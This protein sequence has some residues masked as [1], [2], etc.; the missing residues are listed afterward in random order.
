MAK[1]NGR[2]QLFNIALQET[3]EQEGMNR[4]LK[5]ILAF[6][7]SLSLSTLIV[8]LC[9]FP[10]AGIYDHNDTYETRKELDQMLQQ[11]KEDAKKTEKSV[12]SEQTVTSFDDDF[13]IV[14]DDDDLKEI[15]H[16]DTTTSTNRFRKKSPKWLTESE[17]ENLQTIGKPC[18]SSRV[19]TKPFQKNASKLQK[20]K[21]SSIDSK[22]LVQTSPVSYGSKMVAASIQKRDGSTE[23]PNSSR[24]LSSRRGD[25]I[26]SSDEIDDVYEFPLKI[27]P[28]KRS[29]RNG[30]SRKGETTMEKKSDDTED[31]DFIDDPPP[32]QK[33]YVNRT[34]TEQANPSQKAKLATMKTLCKKYSEMLNRI[35]NVEAHPMPEDLNY[36]SKGPSQLLIENEEKLKVIHSLGYKP[37]KWRKPIILSANSNRRRRQIFNQPSTS[38]TTPPVDAQ[39]ESVDAVE[40]VCDSPPAAS[41][42]KLDISP[43][44]PIFESRKRS[45]GSNGIIEAE[46]EVYRKSPIENKEV[47]QF[48]FSSHNCWFNL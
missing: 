30:N 40:I 25:L 21:T 8:F 46:M 1:N 31:D 29:S 35:E 9:V 42:R 4:R 12:P 38:R 17:E 5:G 24:P 44:S 13:N 32:R 36:D 11:S 6:L 43:A 33:E 39:E 48:Y 2:K 10:E 26:I 23:S 41:M 3:M 47:L 37:I 45:G 27:E 22:K 19:E 28:L 34:K 20:A 16:T 18:S 14:D 15:S 7:K